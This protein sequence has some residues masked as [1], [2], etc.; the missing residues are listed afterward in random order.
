M[1]PDQLAAN[2]QKLAML[3]HQ[4]GAQLARVRAPDPGHS[5]PNVL[6]AQHVV[7]V[8]PSWVCLQAPAAHP[9]STFHVVLRRH[10]VTASRVHRPGRR[11][12]GR[13]A[14]ASGV[15]MATY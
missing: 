14:H 1:P 11:Q 12:T 7:D 4:V 6:I 13:Q 9:R 15:V 5:R 3:Q 2:L 8:R 10:L